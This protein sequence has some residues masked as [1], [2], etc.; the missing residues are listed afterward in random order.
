MTQSMRVESKDKKQIERLE[1]LVVAQKEEHP[2]FLFSSLVAP[3]CSAILCQ[4]SSCI[5][6]VHISV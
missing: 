2:I 6:R 4:V 5:T 1:R 3:N